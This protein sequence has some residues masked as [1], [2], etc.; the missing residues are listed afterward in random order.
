MATK[1][2]PTDYPK[3]SI[4][5]LP[6]GAFGFLATRHDRP[7]RMALYRADGALQSTFAYDDTPAGIADRLNCRIEWIPSRDRV[8]SVFF[9]TTKES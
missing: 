6:D 5:K 8:F 9:P 1:R 4:P 2:N 3:R 7:E